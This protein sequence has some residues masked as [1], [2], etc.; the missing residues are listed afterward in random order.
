M[1]SKSSNGMKGWHKKG[2]LCEKG[3]SSFDVTD[4]SNFLALCPSSQHIRHEY[5]CKWHRGM[6]RGS[7]RGGE[8]NADKATLLLCSQ[9]PNLS[10]FNFPLCQIYPTRTRTPTVRS[11]S[12]FWRHQI[13]G[14][15]ARE[16]REKDRAPRQSQLSRID[17]NR[18]LSNFACE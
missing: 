15:T 7:N 6:R 3:S 9:R 14:L 13:K 10:S 5:V 18:F 11:F 4:L 12:I 16:R 1:L 17:V 8:L 2:T